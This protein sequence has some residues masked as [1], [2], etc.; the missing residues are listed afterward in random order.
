MLGPV[1]PELL[2][3]LIDQHG[4]ALRLYASQLCDSPDDIVQEA[5]IDL[6]RCDEAPRQALAWLYRAVRLR[7]MSARRSTGRRRRHEAEAARR[8]PA[9]VTGPAVGAVDAQL[10]TAALESLPNGQREVVVAR[11]WGGLTFQEIGRVIGISDSAAHRRYTAALNAIRRK[12][13]ESCP[14]KT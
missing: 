9:S 6:A 13:G 8:R 5:L 3:R 7:A 12:L 14:K 10:V 4:A 2:G 11:I 1:G